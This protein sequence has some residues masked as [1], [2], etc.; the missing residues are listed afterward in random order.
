MAIDSMAWHRMYTACTATRKLVA[1][2]P[3]QRDMSGEHEAAV[4]WPLVTAAYNGIEQALKMLLLTPTGSTLTLEDLRSRYGHDLEALYGALDSNDQAH[5]ELHF[6]E[7]W[8]LYEYVRLNL[9]FS[10]AKEF[11]AQLNDS[12]PQVGSIAWRYY[13]LDS[14]VSIPRTNP[15]TMCEVWYAICCCIKKEMY[16]DVDDCFRLSVGL[17]FRFGETLQRI[18]RYDGFIDD[19]NQWAIHKGGNLLVAWVDLLV[20]ANR[21]AMDEVQAPERLRPELASMAATATDRLSDDSAG[22]DD[23]Q[24]MARVRREGRDLVWNPRTAQFR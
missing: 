9:G 2:N 3:V 14:S 17:N 8:S 6:G 5:I 21:D 18:V 7:H 22:P 20:K 23:R 11:V 1:E 24:L 15:W 12:S 4:A 10:T 19:V 13:L 16:P